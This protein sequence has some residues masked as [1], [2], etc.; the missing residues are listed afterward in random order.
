MLTC[1]QIEF[2]GPST[3]IGSLLSNMIS[4]ATLKLKTSNVKA[5]SKNTFFLKKK[6]LLF[7]S[8]QYRIRD[9]TS[10]VTFRF[11]CITSQKLLLPPSMRKLL[12]VWLDI[13]I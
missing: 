1:V 10:G 2:K 5:N 9:K 7:L 8:G 11:R 12:I 6:C 13:N 3:E 4:N